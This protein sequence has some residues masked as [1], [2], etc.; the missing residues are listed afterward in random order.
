MF[1]LRIVT[2]LLLLRLF[3]LDASVASDW[4]SWAT[5]G[6]DVLLAVSIFYDREPE[7]PAKDPRYDR[8]IRR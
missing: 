2:L 3:L 1:S 8:D 6:F 5:V 4:W 7:V